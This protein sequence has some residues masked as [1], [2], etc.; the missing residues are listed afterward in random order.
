M[1]C[2]EFEQQYPEVAESVH[3]ASGAADQDFAD[4]L[5]EANPKSCI[6]KTKK[7]KKAS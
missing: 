3:E 6:K 7:P 1:T 4:S 2:K 5:Y